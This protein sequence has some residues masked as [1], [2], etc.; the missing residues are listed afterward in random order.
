MPLILKRPQAQADL[1]EIWDFIAED[2]E[3]RA[4]SFIESL[5]AKLQTLA[6]SPSLG[7]LRDELAQG[8]RSFPVGRYVIFFTPDG[9]DRDCSS[10]AWGA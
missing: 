5:D 8:L 7:R 4:D 2:S 6:Q 9:R 1:D 10:P 3:E